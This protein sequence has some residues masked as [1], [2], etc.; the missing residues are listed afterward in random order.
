MLDL[1]DGKSR[2]GSIKKE[3]RIWRRGDGSE[4]NMITGV[5]LEQLHCW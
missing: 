3:E 2:F 1:I 4:T 5:L